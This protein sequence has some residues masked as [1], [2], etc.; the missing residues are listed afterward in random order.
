VYTTGSTLSTDQR[1]I[2]QSF[3]GITVDSQAVNGNYDSMQLGFEK[4]MSRGFTILAN[5][6]WAKALDNLPYGQSV[7]GPGPNASGTVYPWY[8]PKADALDY[9]RADFDRRQRFVISYVW[10]LPTPH[11]AGKAVEAV[12]GGWQMNGVFQA[13]TGDPLTVKSGK[14]QSNTGIGGDRAVLVGPALGPGACGA[15][16]PC[17]N[18][19]NP[20]AFAQPPVASAAS[21]YIASFGNFGKGAVSGPG[22]A[23]WD[24][25]LFRSISIHERL[26]LQLRGEFFNVLNRA[27]FSDPVASMSSGGFGSISAASDPRI[28][29]V[30]LKLLF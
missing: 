30:A 6:T 14:D 17:V 28:G 24:V 21:P 13:Q 27:N 1:R 16:A 2:F 15:S 7:T 18:Y 3:S 26:S 4:R 25:G 23:T 9:G 5:Y 11:S 12:F 19:L 22:M 10:Q 8:F 20:S 29:Q